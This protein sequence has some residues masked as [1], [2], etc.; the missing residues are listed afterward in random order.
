MSKTKK[1]EYYVIGNAEMEDSLHT[2]DVYEKIDV[3]IENARDVISG[4]ENEEIFVYK[5]VPVKRIV[6]KNIVENV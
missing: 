1:Q 6:I 3:A 5:L 2:D 4:L